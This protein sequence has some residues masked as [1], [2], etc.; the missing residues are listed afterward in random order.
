MANTKT[1][2][3]TK[4]KT[5]KNRKPVE[6]KDNIIPEKAIKQAENII[7]KNITKENIDNNIAENITEKENARP[8]LWKKGVSANPAGRPKKSD[9]EKNAN[10]NALALIKLHTVD[11]VKT[12]LAVMEN[13]KTRPADRLR[14]AELI[15][16]RA[17]GKAPATVQV[18]TV[19]NS[20][21]ADIKKELR[22]I[23]QAGT[24]TEDKPPAVPAA[25]PVII[26]PPSGLVQGIV[27]A[28]D[29]PM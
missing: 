13:A 21:M 26:P 6:N 14:A 22:N 18:E 29:G 8:W 27:K 2:T 1:G 20:I 16:E 15:L 7:N 12:V 11:A 17:Y 28:V 19:D 23:Q 10:K 3:N 5:T 4:T 25:D 9:A 24:G